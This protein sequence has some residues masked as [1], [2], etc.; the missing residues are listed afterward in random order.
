MTK[1]HQVSRFRDYLISGELADSPQATDKYYI[2]TPGLTVYTNDGIT[3]NT[4]DQDTSDSDTTS[5]SEVEQDDQS[6]G[7][8]STS[9]PSA[10]NTNTA[11]GVIQVAVG[12]QLPTMVQ[13][14]AN[15]VRSDIYHV[16]T[17]LCHSYE[18][19]ARYPLICPGLNAKDQEQWRKLRLRTLTPTPSFDLLLIILQGLFDTERYRVTARRNPL[20]VGKQ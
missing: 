3:A 16:A 10:N 13:D 11:N 6:G 19:S 15:D 1:T 20:S 7:V 12:Q 8:Q 9:N 17:L 14:M 18:Q 5:D 4:L 2:H